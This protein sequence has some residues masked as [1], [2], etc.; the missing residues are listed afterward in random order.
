M[1]NPNICGLVDQMYLEEE[2]V[3]SSFILELMPGI[4]GK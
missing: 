4:C 3:L 2:R 1:A